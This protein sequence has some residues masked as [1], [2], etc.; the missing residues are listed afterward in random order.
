MLSCKVDFND[1]LEDPETGLI[2]WMRIFK[3]DGDPKRIWVRAGYQMAGGGWYESDDIELSN[4][5][6]E[7][8]A[9]HNYRVVVLE[10]TTPTEYFTAEQLETLYSEFYVEKTVV[11]EHKETTEE[12]LDRKAKEIEEEVR[13]ET[14]GMSFEEI[15]ALLQAEDAEAMR[16]DMKNDDNSDNSDDS[17]NSD[18]TNNNTNE[19]NSHD[20]SDEPEN[21]K[22]PEDQEEP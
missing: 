4:K 3:I 20:D 12:E 19:P 1:I 7:A 2:S 15:M 17:D 21:P 6:L 9:A 22:E 8:L 11:E 18:S 13:K 10:G 16:S 14:E 5:V